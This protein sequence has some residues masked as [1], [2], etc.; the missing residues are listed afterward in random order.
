MVDRWSAWVIQSVIYCKCFYS[1]TT[2][3]NLSVEIGGVIGTALVSIPVMSFGIFKFD[4]NMGWCK[5][6]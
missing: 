1:D 4:D 6:I 5:S 2:I 3:K